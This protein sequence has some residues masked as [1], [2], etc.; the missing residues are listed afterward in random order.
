MLPVSMARAAIQMSW[1]GLPAF[2][3]LEK[4]SLKISILSERPLR[5]TLLQQKFYR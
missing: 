2:F 5:E 1:T 4:M 3:R